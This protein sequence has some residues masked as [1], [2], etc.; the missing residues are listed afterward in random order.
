MLMGS[1]L[2][3][4][5]FAASAAEI[6]AV[7][8]WASPDYTRAVFDVSG[9]LDYRLF[10]IANPDRIVLDIRGSVAADSLGIVNGKGLMKSVRTGKQ[11]K[12]DVRV[13][14]DLAGAALPKSFLL[15]PAD[16]LG[17]RL[18]V[19]LYPK[20]KSARAVIKS[21]AQSNSGKTRNVVVMIDPGHGGEDPGAIGASGSHEKNIT[22]SVARELKQMIDKQPGMSAVLTR[23]GDYFVALEDRYK[24][25]R[26]AKAD[27]F[28]SVHADAFSSSDAHGS[29]VWVLSSRGATNQAARWLADRENRSDLVGGVSMDNKDQTLA[30]VLLD[31]Q[32]GATLE[33]SSNIAENVLRALGKIGTTHRGYIERANFVVLRSPDVPSILVETAFISNPSE[34]KR[35]NSP[36]E[37]EKLASAILDGV[38]DYFRATPPP[39]TMFAAN[40]SRDKSSSQHIAARSDSMSAVSE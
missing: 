28:V 16:N 19:D 27:L 20:E 40:A 11:G 14:F 12:G 32:Q 2:L 18:V 5:S 31:L 21:V 23:D 7:R 24:K 8:V 36:G 26:E 13:V 30:A 37:R 25:A 6:S 35:L 1:G 17:Y 34:E 38:R 9:P 3:S 39:G 10:Q 22:M 4:A 15:P 29:S 33:A